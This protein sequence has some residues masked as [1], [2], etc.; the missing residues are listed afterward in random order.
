MILVHKS[1]TSKFPPPGVS[2]R[3]G[4]SAC[5]PAMDHGPQMH[6]LLLPAV[7]ITVVGWLVYRVVRRLKDKKRPDRDRATD[8]NPDDGDRSPEL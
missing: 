8:R 7:A 4:A 3:A 5:F 2:V 1:W 6:L